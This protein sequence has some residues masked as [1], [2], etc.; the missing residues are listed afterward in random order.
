MKKV[1]IQFLPHGREIWVEPGENLLRA[2][3]EAGVH[4]NASCAGQGTCGKCRVKVEKGTV[5]GG[6][7]YNLRPEDIEDGFCLAC[8]SKV[9]GDVTVRIGVESS[10]DP[11]LLNMAASPGAWPELKQPTWKPS[12]KKACSFRRWRRN[13]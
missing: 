11:S 1:K 4:V 5:E 9:N 2:A 12:R 3:M 6:A 7:G 10:V 13:F 8:Q